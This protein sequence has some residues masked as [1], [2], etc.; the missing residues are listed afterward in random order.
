MNVYKRLIVFIV[1]LLVLVSDPAKLWAHSSSNPPPDAVLYVMPDVINLGN[2]VMLDGSAS[3]DSGVNVKKFEWDVNYNGT[4]FSADYT[5]DNYPSESEQK[6]T[7][8]Y[9]AT[10]EYTVA[11]RVT[12]A[13]YKTDTD[14]CTVRVIEGVYNIDQTK[15][16]STIQAAINEANDSDIIEVN[17]ATYRENIDF[18]GVG[19]ILRS[20]DPNNWDVVS[21]TIICAEDSNLATVMFNDSEDANSVIFGFTIT[22]GSSGIECNNTS[23]LI[24]NCIISENGQSDNPGGGVYDYNFAA[25]LITNCIIVDNDANYGGGI[26]NIDSNAVIINSVISDNTASQDGGGIFNKN[27]LPQIV[28]CTITN[29]DANNGGGMYCYGAST[30]P[31]LINCIFWDNNSISL[32]EEVFKAGSAEPN[33]SY[34]D[35]KDC[36][37]SNEV[38]DSNLGTGFIGNID[39][40]PCFALQGEPSDTDIVSHWKF[41]DAN[42]Q[43]AID[44]VGDNNGTIYGADW[45]TGKFGGALD[46]NGVNDYVSVPDSES[47][48]FTVKDLTISLWM[49]PADLNDCG[50]I[51]KYDNWYR[52]NYA[53]WYENGVLYFEV[54]NSAD[55]YGTEFETVV[56]STAVDTND[57][58]YHIVGTYD[59]ENVKLYVNGE[60]VDSNS[61]SRHLGTGTGPLCIGNVKYDGVSNSGANETNG[62]FNGIIDNVMIFDRALSW[63]EISR[64]HLDISSACI[65][66]GDPNGSYTDEVDID[67]HPR[68][69]HER[70]NIGADEDPAVHNITKD[71]YYTTI[72]AGIN[73]A[74]SNDTLVVYRGTYYERIDFNG[75]AV[76]IR[77][78]D[79]ND[80]NIVA[81]T[82]INANSLT[83]D[84]V[85][86]DSGE[87]S[88]S[89]LNGFT[90]TNGRY[91]INC[92][93]SS[94]FITNCTI[95]YNESHGIY[96]KAS[97]PTVEMCRLI[98]NGN[99]GMMSFNYTPAS[100]TFYSYPTIRNCIAAKNSGSGMFIDSETVEFSNCTMY[101]NNS[102]GIAGAYDNIRNCI[103]W[104][105]NGIDLSENCSA[106]YSCIED[107]EPG[108]GNIYI[109]P[110][111]IDSNN[112]DFH[113]WYSSPCI[114]AGDPNG[115]PN[116]DYDDS[117]INMGA[118]GGTSEATIII[119]DDNDGIADQWELLYWPNDDP[120]QHDANE[121][122]DGDKFNNLV[123]YLFRYDPSE[124]TNEPMEIAR[125][126]LST[127]KFDP[128][129]SETVTVQYLLNMDA[130]TVITMSDPCDPNL[131]AAA[132]NQIAVAGVT[133]YCTWDGI[134]DNNEI[135]EKAYYDIS[136]DAN[137]GD[138]NTAD[139]E[140]GIVELYYDHEITNLGC[141]PRR[142]IGTYNEF[143]TI[144]YDIACDANVSIKIYDPCDLLF[145]VLVDNETQQYSQN[146][147][148]IVWSPRQGEPNDPNSKYISEE[149]FYEVEVKLTGMKEKA[150]CN[151]VVYK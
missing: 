13:G 81:A 138:G 32:G 44:T 9:E 39:T 83:E 3:S 60:H 45:V 7:H 42:G 25:P 87:G 126:V 121:N 107:I 150:E 78:T 84:A 141:N 96:C 104:D 22:G 147:Q 48:D 98:R 16:Y 137:A 95:T 46:F 130:N 93:F 97:S 31:E 17:E 12:D 108:Q 143:T 85:M 69:T 34:C 64:Y 41:D 20:T 109:D 53:I 151:L 114:D 74:N 80:P 113:L 131:I 90:V 76:T 59:H 136:I 100:E 2:N 67:F 63:R 21:S 51:G 117:I 94:P 132:I 115:D 139:Y 4:T 71:K 18:N 61:E 28:N 27:C 106:T 19:C 66:A 57:Q 23:P 149:G 73:D 105:N 102:F 56:S 129:K 124:D 29:N 125:V 58:W 111:F 26:Y 8:E 142:V 36:Y 110:M 68:V 5:R 24:Q 14:Y 62:Q 103:I 135:I 127:D 118:Y 119:D 144:T 89:I 79:P 70:I 40:D 145:L 123:E 134:D 55:S 10:G 92:T 120:N 43:I 122:L 133:K 49:K 11:L 77:S 65:N 91:G 54:G 128:T 101:G 37:D 38:W 33:F 116:K 75:T 50:I 99:T 140:V 112:S 30:K 15:F 148:Q 35:I 82:I 47:V 86:F 88:S 52:Y 1:V 72:Q 146:P 6:V